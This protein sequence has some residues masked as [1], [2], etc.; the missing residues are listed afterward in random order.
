[1]LLF[2]KLLDPIR[3]RFRERLNPYLGNLRQHKLNNN[4]FTIISNNCWGGMYIV[5][6]IYLMILLL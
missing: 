2:E 4:K 1:M 5:F 6:L 3:V